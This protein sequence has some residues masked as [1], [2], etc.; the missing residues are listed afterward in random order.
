L[1]WVQGDQIWRIFAHRAAVFVGQ[2]FEN[3]K[4]SPNFLATFFSLGYFFPLLRLC[5]DFDK[6]MAWATSWAIF[7][8]TRPVALLRFEK[9]APTRKWNL[10][11][12]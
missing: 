1:Y 11:R 4:C 7:S 6:K 9:V 5:I 8:Q 3:E 12:S 10:L 2:I